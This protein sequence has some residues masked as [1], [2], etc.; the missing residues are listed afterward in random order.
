MNVE[1]SN[2]CKSP[3]R[4]D[5]QVSRKLTYQERTVNLS[6]TSK[7]SSASRLPWIPAR[8]TLF[9]EIRVELQLKDRWLIR[10][11]DDCNDLSQISQTLRWGEEAMRILDE[12]AKRL[13][14]CPILP[15][16]IAI[17]DEV[18]DCVDRISF[19]TH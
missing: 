4:I 10:K 5:E 17:D 19:I 2:L 7:S 6:G 1:A 9:G 11:V 16:S 8:L 12:A 14:T 13:T 3:D 18:V 15:P